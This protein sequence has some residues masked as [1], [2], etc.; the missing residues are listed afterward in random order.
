M[1]SE[2]AEDMAYA[3]HR[4]YKQ[5]A[6]AGAFVLSCKKGKTQMHNC[7]GDDVVEQGR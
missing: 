2:K 1:I 4:A 6:G 5:T 3:L 7:V